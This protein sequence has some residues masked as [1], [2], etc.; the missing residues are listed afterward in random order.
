[1]RILG[2]VAVTA[3]LLLGVV[4]C[5]NQVT[6]TATVDPTQPPLGLS[7]DGYGIVAGYPDAPVQIELYTEPQCTHCAD[8]QAAF[9]EDMRRHINL[10]DLAVTYRPLTFLDDPSTDEHSARV[11][12]ALFLAV[13]APEASDESNMASGPE[14]QSFVEE[15]WANQNPGGPGPSDQQMAKMAQ[16]SGLPEEVATRI[17][18]GEIADQIE[19]EEMAA[20]NYGALIGIDPI[21]TGTPTVYDLS[22]GEKVNI[23][24]DDWLDNLLSAV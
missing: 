18:N 12:N 16:E 24:E 19:I 23:H 7:D 6:G 2:A 8:L 1:M 17:G 10:G 22:T 20:Y 9:G 4:G 15:L 11:A 5:T 3:A 14:F 21:T 13:G